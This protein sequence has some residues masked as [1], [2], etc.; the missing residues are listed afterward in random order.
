MCSEEECGICGEEQWQ[1]VK[2]KRKG[3]RWNKAKEE[4][5]VMAL[6]KEGNGWQGEWVEIDM[7]VDSGA[8]DSVG[9]EEL[10]PGI[11]IRETEASRRK[12]EYKVANGGTIR[13]KGE[14]D[15][16][17]I[18]EEGQN[19]SMTFQITDVNKVLASV[20]R[21]CEAGNTVVFDE[22]GS[23]I[24]NKKSGKKTW[25]RKE[26]GVYGIRVKVPTGGGS[27]MGFVGLEELI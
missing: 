5:Q 22:E 19:A 10:A 3:R 9:S 20:R 15:I 8:S 25:M 13:N 1:E 11:E 24:L 17:M 7:T 4:G 27:D 14:K 12:L 26:R 6:G 23:Y 16:P 18:T 21:I 2:K